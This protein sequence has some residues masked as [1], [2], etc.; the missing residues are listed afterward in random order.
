MRVFQ[1]GRKVTR[2]RVRSDHLCPTIIFL[3][4]YLT[5]QWVPNC[6]RLWSIGIHFLRDVRRVSGEA[7]NQAPWCREAP[8]SRTAVSLVA[9]DIAVCCLAASISRYDRTTLTA[10]TEQ[11]SLSHATT[12]CHE[13]L[14]FRNIIIII[15]ILFCRNFFKFVQLS[16]ALCL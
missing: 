2:K 16:S 1:C 14:L 6:G 10:T 3:I 15:W 8:L 11:L 13:Q 7:F 12:P 9:A 4:D 5:A